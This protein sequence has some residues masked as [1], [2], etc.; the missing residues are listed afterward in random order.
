M[1]SPKELI[2][3]EDPAV[4]VLTHALGWK[5]LDN[6]ATETMMRPSLKE[7]ILLPQLHAA[8]RH[9]NPWI[10]SDNEQRVIREVTN[11]QATSVIEANEKL[12]T[13]LVRGAT[14]QQDKNDGL[15][16]KSHG[17]Y[18]IDFERPE[19]NEFTVVRQFHVKNYVDCYPDLTLFVNG[20]PIVV[21]ECKSPGIRDPKNEGLAQ[22]M[23]Y[24]E[25]TDKDRNQGLPAALQYRANP[26][27]HLPR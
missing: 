4:E 25:A 20:I 17:V 11:I 18:L 15:G 6:S 2:E 8:I 5:E 16:M 21:I 24:Q 3:T 23:R 10:S 9:L 14:V 26:S 27:G 22:L 12:H 19:K 1:R 13:I 7:A